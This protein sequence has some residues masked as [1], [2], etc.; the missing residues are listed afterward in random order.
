MVEETNLTIHVP[1][2]RKLLDEN[3]ES[4]YIETVPKRGEKLNSN[5]FGTRM[6]EKTEKWKIAVKMFNFIS[7]VR[8][9]PILKLSKQKKN[10]L[11]RYSKVCFEVFVKLRGSVNYI[12]KNS[13]RTNY[14]SKRHYILSGTCNYFASEISKE[15]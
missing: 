4:R 5:E 14:Q 6:A 13:L 11:F 2:L 12:L 8:D 9:S 3:N 7:S 15:K 10:K 1:A